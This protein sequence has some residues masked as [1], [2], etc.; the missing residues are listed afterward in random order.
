L[1]TT[2]GNTHLIYVRA[3]RTGKVIQ[4]SKITAIGEM[5]GGVVFVEAVV[6]DDEE[7]HARAAAAIRRAAQRAGMRTRRQLTGQG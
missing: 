4:R 1:K 6:L 5:P 2:I 7:R 3:R